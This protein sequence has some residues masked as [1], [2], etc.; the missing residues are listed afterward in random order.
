MNEEKI[1]S[2][3]PIG[4]VVR[5]RNLGNP[6]MIYGVIQ[7][8]VATGEIMEYI[9]VMWPEGSMGAGTQFMF[10]HDDIR[11]VLFKGLNLI[12]R[13]RFIEALVNANRNGEFES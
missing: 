3:L 2:L 1:R 11:E 10:N 13:D 6:M 12:E 9:S 5:V 4:S 7:K 8:D